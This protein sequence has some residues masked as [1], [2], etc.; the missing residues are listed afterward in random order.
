MFFLIGYR[1]L[2]QASQRDCGVF[3]GDTNNLPGCDPVQPVLGEPPLAGTL[4]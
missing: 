3:S 2:E 1:A 4:H